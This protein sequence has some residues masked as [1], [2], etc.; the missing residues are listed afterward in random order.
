MNQLEKKPTRRGHIFVALVLLLLAVATVT[1][2][3]GNRSATAPAQK[4]VCPMHPNIVAD[5]PG[6]CPICGMKMVPEKPHPVAAAG[7]TAAAPAAQT[8]TAGAA[9]PGSRKIKFYRSPMNPAQTS[10]VPMKD[11]MGM[12]YLPVYEDGGAPPSAVAGRAEVTIDPARQQLIGLR[13]A[14]VARG[15]VGGAWRTVGRVQVD[16]TAVRQTNVR[17]EGY[18]DKVLVDFV[19]QAVK[20]GDPLFSLYSPEIFAA[21][22]E[23]LI[24]ART[25]GQLAGGMLGADGDA[26]MQAAQARLRLLDVPE[27]EIGRLR[28]TGKPSRSITLVS[29]VNGVVTVKNVTEGSAVRPGD[30]PYEITDLSTVWVMAD[31]YETDLARVKDGMA[32]TLMVKAYPELTFTGEVAFIDPELNPETR[33]LK[34]HLHF[35]NPGQLLKPEMFGDVTLAGD[36]RSAL[37]IPADAVI[38]TG[39]RD[40]VFVSLGGGRFSPREV[41]LGAK[42]GD[43]VEV[44]TGLVEGEEVVTR[45]NFLIDSESALRA[46]LAS[47]GE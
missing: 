32:A 39:E 28:R 42:S 44:L 27:A 16:P 43:Q 35:Q 33:T 5:K 11:E 36:E 17:V 22:Q 46:S 29:P 12:D 23:Y 15:T 26:L 4:Y 14:R 7:G 31:A 20:K 40:V 18:I 24:A 47:L 34:V 41:K 9:A 38:P 8:T 37:T 6:D 19:G 2:A 13:T 45:A 30:T 21:E 3:C 25:R 1:V 10:P